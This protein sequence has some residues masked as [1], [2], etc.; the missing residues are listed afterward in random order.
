ML[1]NTPL[2]RMGT[3][4]DIAHSVK[5]LVSEEAISLPATSWT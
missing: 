2:R 5:F 1:A 4:E 3:P